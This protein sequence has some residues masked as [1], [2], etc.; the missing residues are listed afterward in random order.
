MS[1][2]L[3]AIDINPAKDQD[4]PRWSLCNDG[5]RF[6]GH[7]H[8]ARKSIVSHREKNTKV[9]GLEQTNACQVG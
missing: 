2:M 9:W 8:G 5:L 7:I 1:T 6:Q 4:M 3:G